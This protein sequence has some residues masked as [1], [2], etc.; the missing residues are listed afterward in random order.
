MHAAN[1]NI[2]EMT[3]L[4]TFAGAKDHHYHTAPFRVGGI[5][6]L[7]GAVLAPMSGITDAP[8]RRLARQTWRR[9]RG[10]GNDRERRSRARPADVGPAFGSR[11]DRPACRAAGRLRDALDG[12][13]RTYRARTAGADIIDINMGCPA[14]HVTNGE[15]GSALMRDLD[16]ALR[17]IEATVDAVERAGDAEDAARL[18]HQSLNAPDL[19][20]RAEAAGVRMITV[21]GRTRCQFYKGT[22][23]LARGPRGEGRNRNSALSSMATF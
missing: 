4:A 7:N 12:G 9:S 5:E 11:R 6:P 2:A 22:R 20:R 14:R 23:R 10:V 3:D 8:F 21:H 18:G 1:K 16:H 19:A 13:G 15:S 17:L